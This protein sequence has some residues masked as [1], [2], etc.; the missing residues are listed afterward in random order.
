[1]NAIENNNSPKM[2]VS[3][4]VTVIERDMNS[5]LKLIESYKN[6]KERQS[7]E[8]I[9]MFEGLSNNNEE[10]LKQ[11]CDGIENISFYIENGISRCRRKDIA[12]EHAKALYLI[13]VDA[14]CVLDS[15]YYLNLKK[16]LNGA[17]VIRGKNIYN[18]S[19]KYISKCNAIYRTLAD[20][21]V[22]KDETFTPNLIIDKKFLTDAGGWYTDNIDSAD[23][24]TLSHRLKKKY[25]FT[26]VHA[27][28]VIINISNDADENLAR[29]ARVW[30]GYGNGYGFR[31]RLD[32]K[33]TFKSFF[34]FIP[35]FVYSFKK[36]LF[37]LPVAVLNLFY[38]TRGYMQELRKKEP[39]KESILT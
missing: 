17:R 32:G 12:I 39:K 8:L 2:E 29:L 19:N 11:K 18:H 34:K 38:V 23:D 25:A 27:E 26:I 37:Y 28:D 31:L 3:F 35:P 14:D 4:I 5:L 10:V 30:I 6:I 16:Y 9:I 7:T 22:F 15:S 13:Y 1:M 21:E 24:F 20:D 36:P 33:L